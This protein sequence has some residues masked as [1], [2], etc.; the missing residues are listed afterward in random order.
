MDNTLEGVLTIK[1]KEGDLVAIG[2][3]DMKKRSIILYSVKE[4]GIDDVKVLLD[5]MKTG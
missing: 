5:N 4:M 3:N 1:S 2:F